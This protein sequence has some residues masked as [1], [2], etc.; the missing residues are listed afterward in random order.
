MYPEAKSTVPWD[1]ADKKTQ[2][3][4]FS[5]AS[6]YIVIDGI[7]SESVRSVCSTLKA[8]V[9][10]CEG[11][12]CRGPKALKTERRRWMRMREMRKADST[13]GV[14][15]SQ[16]LRH[17]SVLLVIQ[18]TNDMVAGLI[19][20]ELPSDVNIRIEPYDNNQYDLREDR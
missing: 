3:V 20:I 10:T 12:R 19:G 17:R 9:K 1:L 16:T 15:L 2:K 4:R 8:Y 5:S 18:P 13:K 14:Y 7:R 6:F 11:V